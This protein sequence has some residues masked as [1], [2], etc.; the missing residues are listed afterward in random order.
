MDIDVLRVSGKNEWKRLD[1]LTRARSLTGEE[2]DELDLLYRYATTDL[3]RVRTKSPD[4]DLIADLSRLL[5]AARGR[6]A[7]TSG[8]TGAIIARF[9]VVALPLAM[10][11]I[12]WVI[13]GVMALFMALCVIQGH[14]LLTTPD[15]MS[16]LGS[17]EAL[18]AYAQDMFVDYYHQD[19]HAQFGLSVWANNSW[20]CLQAVATGITGFY[21]LVLL[22]NNAVSLGTSAAVVIQY[23]GVWHFFRFILPHGLPELTAVFISMAA[24]LRVFWVFLVPG[25]A[26][27]FQAVGRAARGAMTAAFG[28]AILLAG[29]GFL[30]GFVTPSDLPDSVKIVLGVILTGAAWAYILILGRM[31]ERA[32]GSD[33]VGTDAGYYQPVAG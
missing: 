8:L 23:G 19:T 24:G 31:A 16:A 2:I 7:G 10:Y 12:R 33:D 20:I 3:A 27:R 21:P 30:E 28:A 14:Y 32:G 6:L 26:T 22:W 5:S 1:Q 17:P 13:V 25:D 4:P 9:F 29:S 11:R 15:A 18:R